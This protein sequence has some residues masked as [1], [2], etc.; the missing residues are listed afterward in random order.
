LGHRR[1]TCI[2]RIFQS[3][4]AKTSFILKSL[5]LSILRINANDITDRNAGYEG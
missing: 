4:N 5:I 3:D 1:H 2:D